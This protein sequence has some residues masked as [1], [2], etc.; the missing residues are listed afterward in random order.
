[1]P[2]PPKHV[3][4]APTPRK[5]RS[6]KLRATKKSGEWRHTNI[7]RLL[8]NALRRFETRVFELLA[9]ANHTE[10][11]LTHLNLTRNLDEAGTRMTELARRAGVTKQAIGELIVQCEDLGLIKRVS[12]PTDARAKLVKFTE[13]GLE[14]LEA[15]RAALEQAEQ[16]MRQELG[17]LCVD[18]LKA[19]LTTYA[20]AY[21]TLD[22]DPSGNSGAGSDQAA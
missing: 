11:R 15:F 1:M 13:R 17:T 22:R 16:E 14:W 7:G 3:H 8:N 21:D 10:A 18:G 19:A 9:Q 12:D 5:T 6:E 4:K 20:E 2:H